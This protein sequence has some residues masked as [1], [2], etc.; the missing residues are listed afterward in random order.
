MS[1]LSFRLTLALL[2]VVV[3]SAVVPSLA[4]AQS[5]DSDPLFGEY[6][7]V[8]ELPVLLTSVTPV[9]PEPAKRAGIDGI[10]TVQALVGK[11]GRVKDV[12]IVKSVPMLD[13]A[14]VKAVRQFVFKPAQSKGE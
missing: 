7:Y 6:V 5:T 8:A 2:I 4:G 13:Q 1:S 9:Y 12:R 3:V 10:V 14:A 11:D